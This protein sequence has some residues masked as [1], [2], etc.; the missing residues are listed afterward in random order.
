M[1]RTLS[2]IARPGRKADW[3]SE[4]MSLSTGRRRSDKI[5]EIIL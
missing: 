4:I 5:F 1:I 2:A 3:F